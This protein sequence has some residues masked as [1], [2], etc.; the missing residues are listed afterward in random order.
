MS[1]FRLAVLHATAG[2]YVS[3]L[4]G[5]GS[6]LILARLLLP[7]EVGVYSVGAAVLAIIHVFRDF[8][9]SQYIVREPELDDAKLGTCFGIAVIVAWSF[10]LPLALLAPALATFFEQ[11]GL[12]PVTWIL[13]GG[14]AVIPFN[15]VRMALLRRDMRFGVLFG[16][17]VASA[18]ANAVVAVTLAALGFSFLS[19]AWGAFASIAGTYLAV[20]LLASDVRQPRATLREWR[21]VAG[22]GGQALGVS[23]VTRLGNSAPDFIIGK[24]SGM[25]EVGILSRARGL[26]D[27]LQTAFLNTV[28][29]VTYS[30]IARSHRAGEPV[31]PDYLRSVTY[32]SVL[33]WPCYAFLG[34]NSL[35][36]IRVLF[37]DNWDASAPLV[38][39]FALA[40]IFAPL[41]MFNGQFFTAIGRIGTQFRIQAVSQSFKVAAWLLV[42]P[43]SLETALQAYV[44]VHG[45]TAL[46]S[47]T[48]LCRA[49]GSSFA[50]LRDP[51]RDGLGVT[52]VALALPVAG[53]LAGLED[54]IGMVGAL[55]V[56]VV[57]LAGG[58]LAGVYALGH[59]V[60]IEIENA[61][62]RVF[63]RPA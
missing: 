33:A 30:H 39:V 23:L 4:I 24:S 25:A 54:R 40:G 17:D 63:G 3:L 31:A 20:Q 35:A 15:S 29:T 27:L 18:T 13:A 60:R 38:E 16:A 22:F 56:D 44:V 10:A 32:L 14:L 51:L 28:G 11:P 12:A 6:T 47:S 26:V 9:V 48:L 43:Y 61:R 36:V 1:G 8:G 46:V 7:E 42:I 34:L 2:R 5:V 62:R 45:A 49:L 57:A 52:L 50:A 53:H 19:L 37:G 59:P 41:W 58:W 55:T 21:G